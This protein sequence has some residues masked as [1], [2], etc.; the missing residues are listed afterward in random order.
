MKF[1]KMMKKFKNSRELK[2]KLTRSHAFVDFFDMN[3][4]KAVH[5]VAFLLGS[6]YSSVVLFNVLNLH[7]YTCENLRKPL[8]LADQSVY[9]SKYKGES[10]Y[11]YKLHEAFR[12]FVQHIEV[13]FALQRDRS[14][15]FLVGTC[16][17]K[18]SDKELQKRVH[19]IFCLISSYA[20]LINI[21]KAIV[22]GKIFPISNTDGS[23]HE[24]LRSS[25]F[26]LLDK[27]KKFEE[28]IPMKYLF[29]RCFLH[30]TN[31]LFITY[32]QLEEY[33][34]QCDFAPSEIGAFLDL[35]C[36]CCSLF[37]LEE[38]HE[39]RFVILQPSKFIK[40][41]DLIYSAKESSGDQTRV[42]LENGLLSD[43]LARSIW[44]TSSDTD[45]SISDYSFYKS[46]LMSFGLMVIIESC[47]D[48][49]TYFMPSLRSDYNTEKPTVTS[50]S[51][52]IVY[53]ISVIPC[54]KQCAFVAHFTNLRPEQEGFTLKLK[55]CS[56]YNVVKFDCVL[57]GVVKAE[58]MVRFRYDYLELCIHS[59]SDSLEPTIY[60]RLKTACIQVLSK[61]CADY[62]GLK[63]KLAIICP[64]SE[65]GDPHFIPFN[66]LNGSISSLKCHESKCPLNGNDH[67][68]STHPAILWVKSAYSGGFTTAVHPN[69]KCVK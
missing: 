51:M 14:N 8:D 38:E 65:E 24:K 5:E 34:N 46:V 17:D 57:K 55:E 9:G 64:R 26:H 7:H 61:I 4:N 59:S 48:N 44:N 58:A 23:D 16:A 45:R 50:N 25:Y 49:T 3:A 20:Q 31:K 22:G 21:D 15:A 18:L 35:F 52:I 41:L 63:Y 69:G 54:H 12:Y 1:F 19:D 62:E 13:A 27:D 39:H 11:L 43:D 42:Q 66:P 28:Y 67:D 60:S 56:D 36:K 32:E 37:L 47:D 68:F 53:N 33:A 30:S 29:L 10:A 6:K 2:V 40:G